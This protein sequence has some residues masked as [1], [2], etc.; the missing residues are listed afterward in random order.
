MCS[1]PD[2]EIEPVT[3]FDKMPGKSR[4]AL[5]ED[6]E[7]SCKLEIWKKEGQLL[8]MRS[9]L[10]VKVT[11]KV[12]RHPGYGL[13]C[14]IFLTINRAAT[15]FNGCASPACASNCDKIVVPSLSIG[16][17]NPGARDACIDTAWAA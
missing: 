1:A 17:H 10:D 7:E 13:A 9:T 3:G 16:I 8:G 11:V 15:I 2:K 6:T 5:K 14:P 4:P 12:F